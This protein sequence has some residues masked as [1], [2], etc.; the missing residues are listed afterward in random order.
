M[1]NFHNPQR[2]VIAQYRPGT[3]GKFLAAC[4]MTIDRIA[5]WDQRVENNSIS[6][7]DWVNEQWQ[8]STTDKWIAYEPLHDWNTRFFSRTFPRGND[9]SI[10]DYNIGMNT[11]ASEYLRHL[12]TNT[13]KLI[14]DFINKETLPAWWK[15]A[16]IVKLDTHRGCTLHKKFLLS[17]LYPWNKQTKIGTN[18]MDAPLQ[19]NKSK[20][21]SVYQNQY[22]FGPFASEDEWYDFVWANDFRL[23]FNLTQ[24]DIVLTNLLDF[25]ALDLFIS[26]TASNL[27]SNYQ[28]S[29]LKYVWQYWIDKNKKILSTVD[30]TI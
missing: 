29:D 22:E 19:E 12:W 1:I 20:N 15:D 11:D 18:M 5:H 3:G 26:K 10:D 13:D 24:P 27:G 17:K 16:S 8:Q 14:L 21:A 2:W 7:I 28:R 23:N 25:D 4:L 6:Y 30:T 9:I